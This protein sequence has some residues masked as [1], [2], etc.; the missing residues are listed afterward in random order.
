M[1]LHFSHSLVIPESQLFFSASHFFQS[2]PTSGFSTELMLAEMNKE[3]FNVAASKSYFIFEGHSRRKRG[4]EGTIHCGM[5]EQFSTK[6]VV[7]PGQ[8][9]PL[10][11][12]FS[13][14]RLRFMTRTQKH[15]VN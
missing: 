13:H 4:K 14:S 2:F 8:T 6:Q 1:L 10:P 5:V 11:L 15:E 9:Q 3:S 12:P 7:S